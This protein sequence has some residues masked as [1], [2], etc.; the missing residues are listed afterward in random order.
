MSGGMFIFSWT[1]N[2]TRSLYLIENFDYFLDPNN[3]TTKRRVAD[4][5]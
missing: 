3:K 2:N 1:H 4:T 5:T